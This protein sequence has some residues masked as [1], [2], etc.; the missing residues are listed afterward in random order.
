MS[1]SVSSILAAAEAL[2]TAER[3]E[4]IDLLAAGLDDATPAEAE[5]GSPVLREAWRQEIARRSAELDAGRAE[6]VSWREV[7][8]RWKSR[9]A[10]GG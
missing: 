1:P 8:E 2:T 9:R 7:Q 4:L 3:R 5:Q 6:T 10:A